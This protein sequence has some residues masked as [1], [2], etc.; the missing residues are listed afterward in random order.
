MAHDAL[1]VRISDGHVPSGDIQYDDLKRFGAHYGPLEAL[2]AQQRA[3]P[4]SVL[5]CPVVVDNVFRMNALHHCV[6]GVALILLASGCGSSPTT[7]PEPG[8]T[9]RSRPLYQWLREHPRVVRRMMPPDWTSWA[10]AEYQTLYTW[11]FS[12]ALPAQGGADGGEDTG[13]ESLGDA[14]TE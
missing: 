3:F 11:L 9:P 7:S 2:P 6:V 12:C 1:L 8:R 10:S 5:V 14:S 13:T 4:S